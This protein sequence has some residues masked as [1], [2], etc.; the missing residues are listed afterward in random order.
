MNTTY[1]PDPVPIDAPGE[2]AVRLIPLGGLGEIGLNMMLIESRRRHPGGRLRPALPGRRDAGRRLRHPGLRLSPR[3]PR[4]LSR[5]GAH[6]RPRGSHRRAVVPP[7]GVRRCRCTA[8]RSPWRSRGIVSPSTACSTRPTCA[9]YAPGDR[10]VV[11]GFT[12]EPI[13]VTHSIADGI[14]LAIETPLGTVVHTGDFKLDPQPVDRPAAGLLALRRAGR[15][16]RAR[17]LLG[18]DERRPAGP[19][20]LGDAT[21][22]RRSRAASPRRRDASSWPRSP[23][24]STASSRC[25]IW[26][27][28]CHRKV[29][30]LGRS[31]MANVRWPR[32]WAT[33]RCR[34]A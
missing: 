30:L 28:S 12:V 14:G 18:L 31:M 27:R 20:G 23:R 8:R 11:G 22:A 13:R 29:A 33:S 25:S 6:A 1:R 7:A 32:S 21:S 4:R 16:R 34:R 5:R 9:T 15:A 10:I 17:A 2:P 24:T 19:H 26:R 3:A